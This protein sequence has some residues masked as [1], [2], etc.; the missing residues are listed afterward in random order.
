MPLDTDELAPLPKP[1]QIELDMMSIEALTNR[2]AELEGEIAHI[3]Q[4]IVKK[5][6]SRSAADALFKR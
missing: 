1:K 2:I 4:L 6:G 3:R 5:Q